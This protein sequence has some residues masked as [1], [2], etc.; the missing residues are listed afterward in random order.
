MN[1]GNEQLM[2]RLRK[3]EKM[4]SFRIVNLLFEDKDL[5]KKRRS[6]TERRNSSSDIGASNLG[7]CPPE[8]VASKKKKNVR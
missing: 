3:I 5:K 2:E 7:D 4:S 1:I 6:F 8:V